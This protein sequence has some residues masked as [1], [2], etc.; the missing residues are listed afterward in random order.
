MPTIRI[1]Y[2]EKDRLPLF[3]GPVQESV[4]QIRAACPST[5]IYIRTGWLFGPHVEICVLGETEPD[6]TPQVHLIREW[7]Q[8]HPSLCRL[9]EAK[10]EKLS[11]RAG[12]LEGIDGP[13]GPLRSNNM[14]EV[15]PYR[16]P[17]LVNG[18]ESLQD[19]YVRFFD[20]TVP[21][22]FRIL[23]LKA[24]DVSLANLT[25][26]AMLA[27]T[28]DQYEPEGLA[29]GYI[30]LQAHADFFFAN[31]DHSGQ[32]RKRNDAMVQAW[33]EPLE[34]ALRGVPQHATVNRALVA[35]VREVMQLWKQ[36]LVFAKAEVKQ[37]IRVDKSWFDYNPSVF[38]DELPDDP[39]KIKLF[40][41]A[42]I[43]VSRIEKGKTLDELM[44][45]M[46][47][48]FFRSENFQTFRVMLNMFYSF[49]RTL[50]VSP[51]ERFAFCYAV[52]TVYCGMRDEGRL[53]ASGDA[54]EPMPAAPGV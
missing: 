53:L 5:L 38:P 23:S 2:H 50:S 19:A 30:S 49:L 17:R 31:F 8:L 21:V 29:R 52:S 15:V 41:D 43:A 44:K 45:N 18:H 16:H 12:L 7:L 3:S 26:I 22:L 14:V 36:V 42:S 46:D 35:Q 13:Y 11:R 39:A 48:A 51:A 1:D 33:R 37:V 32:F 34:K 47:P 20:R 28:A 27:R 40:E 9:S 10:Y 4:H 54:T 6:C 25:L 24:S